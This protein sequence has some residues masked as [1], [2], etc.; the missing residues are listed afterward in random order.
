MWRRLLFF[1]L[2]LTKVNCE[3][4]KNSLSE[5]FREFE[6]LFETKKALNFEDFNIEASS[7]SYP[8][9]VQLSQIAEKGT[10][11]DLWA[12]KMRDSWGGVPS[13][14]YSANAFDF[15]NYDQCV[16]ID[17]NTSLGRIVGQHCLL[18]IPFERYGEPRAEK[19]G[20]AFKTWVSGWKF[21]LNSWFLCN[22]SSKFKIN[23]GVCV[24]KACLKRDVADIFN[25]TLQE[26]FGYNLRSISCS[27]RNQ[28]SHLQGSRMNIFAM[29][30]Q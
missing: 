29:W 9:S 6:I 14:V 21:C 17:E 7:V 23:V 8:C 18:S 20:T 5:D 3:F 15:G 28:N 24:P 25:K 22:F 2:I 4:L 19:M 27:T 13:G 10:S 11:R 26:D 16:N 1:S 30:V 12:R